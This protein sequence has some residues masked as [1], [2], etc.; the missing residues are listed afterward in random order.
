MAPP[1]VTSDDGIALRV[2]DLSIAYPLPRLARRLDAVSGVSF[3]VAAGS[4]VSLVGPSGCGKTS[5]L[6]AVAG[7]LPAFQGRVSVHGRTVSGPGRDRALVFQHASLLPWRTVL[8]NV[9]YGLECHRV[10]RPAARRRARELVQL[11][12]LA[13]FEHHYPHELSGGMQQRVNLAR[14]LAVEPSLL[15]MDEPFAALDA[16]T[17]ETMQGELMRIWSIRRST[18]LFITHQIDEAVYLS[19][20]V[21]VLS[22]RPGRIKA[23]VDV[24][25]PRPRSLAVKR[26]ERFL[27][28]TRRVWELIEP[29]GAQLS[30]GPPQD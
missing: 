21:V 7:L 20:R 27:D 17:R 14:A 6:N 28:V 13:G 18:V 11:V 12:E 22:A 8:G 15:L 24:P 4:F 30:S 29:H 25:L 5:I 19:D 2:E 10:G 16:Q 1:G 3:D 26:T 23:V 9:A